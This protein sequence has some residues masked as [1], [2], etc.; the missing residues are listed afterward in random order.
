[1]IEYEEADSEYY[2]GLGTDELRKL[3]VSGEIGRAH[4]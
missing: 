1:M 2:L 4:V 3:T